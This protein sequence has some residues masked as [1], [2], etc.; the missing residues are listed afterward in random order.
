MSQIL[1]HHIGHSHAESSGEVLDRHSLLL[2]AVLQKVEQAAR[3]SLG[4]SW[5]VKFDG[6]FLALCHL[7]EIGDVGGY[8]RNP[9]RTCKMCH[10]AAS[11]RRGVRHNRNRGRLEQ[12]G[13]II[14]RN[15]TAKLDALIPSA[16]PLH[17]VD[18][19]R[20]LRM[21]AAGDYEFGIGH[22]LREQ[23]ESFNH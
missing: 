16:L 14:F 7:P 12:L 19:A 20:S 22:L 17:R 8:H 18:V 10:T 15:V 2:F 1:L 23:I 11:R 21:I 6:Q 5:W 9:V 3:K 13:Q 4:I